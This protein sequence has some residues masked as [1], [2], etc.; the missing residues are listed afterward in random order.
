MNRFI[1]PYLKIERNVLQMI[2]AEFFIQLV[3][4]SFM[5]ILNIY[6]SKKGFSDPKIADFI[7]IRFFTVMLLAFPLGLF[8]KGR[9]LI[10]FFYFASIGV[11]ICSM[12]ILFSVE[13]NQ[14]FFIYSGLALWG[15][16]YGFMQVLA[17]P[18]ILRNTSTE[19][20]TSAISLSYATYSIA[21]IASGILIFILSKINEN[22]FNEFRCLVILSIL[23]T[24]SLYFVFKMKKEEV[25]PNYEG[26]RRDLG[27][28][29]WKVIA[30]AMTPSLM[31]AIG[32]GL[33]IP[34]INL[35][36]YKV[37]KMNSDTFAII[38]AFSSIT[39][40]LAALLV[41]HIK[42]KYGY[43]I[44]I[45]RT[46]TIAVVSLALLACTEYFQ[47]SLYAYYLAIFFFL[48]RQPLMN[49][50]APVASELV[51][52]YVGPK[53]QEIIS[54][55]TA[56]IW[57]GSWFFSAIIFR[58]LR[59]QGFAYANVFLITAA[60]YAFAVIWYYY[61]I[62]EHELKQK[63]QLENNNKLDLK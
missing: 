16:S 57:S 49:M 56:S 7:S 58:I 59:H 28:F 40:A 9:K 42:N 50:A 20:Q 61:L 23:S 3:N 38:N 17:L 34:F 12:V 27:N 55:L 46:Q 52:S 33:T 48:L 21:M 19:N 10:P 11:S 13:F 45:T 39:V 26:K 43:K 44:A 24:F 25:I 15:L 41:P 63:I 22:Y 32:A 60:I 37:F 5:M 31:L 62:Q 1:K 36:F 53:N 2:L 30:F 35:F 18:F 29:D 8:I 6:L 14:P 47:T 4:A 51:M 54:A